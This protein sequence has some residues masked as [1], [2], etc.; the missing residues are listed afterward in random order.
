MLKVSKIVN[1]SYF[2]SKVAEDQ[3]NIIKY[4]VNN[5]R[6]SMLKV[7][8]IVNKIG[9]SLLVTHFESPNARKFI[10]DSLLSHHSI[11]YDINVI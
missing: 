10:G 2:G 4:S 7:S 9:D 5:L 1:K 11:S 6:T 3:T 8:R